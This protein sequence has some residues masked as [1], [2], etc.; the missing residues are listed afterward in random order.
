M[1]WAKVK[2][3]KGIAWTP[4]ILAGASNNTVKGLKSVWIFLTHTDQQFVWF[5][6]MD[7]HSV[8]LYRLSICIGPSRDWTC[9]SYIINKTLKP[10]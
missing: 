9:V 10:T 2:E 3:G 1:I 4:S 8:G 5:F 7:C 6:F